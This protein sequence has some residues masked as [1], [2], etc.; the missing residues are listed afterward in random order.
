MADK[1]LYWE[2][3]KYFQKML[4]LNKTAFTEKIKHII[5]YSKSGLYSKFEREGIDLNRA[6]KFARTFNIK[7]EVFAGEDQKL[8]ESCAMES[9]IEYYQVKGQHSTFDLSSLKEHRNI[10]KSLDGYWLEVTAGSEHQNYNIGKFSSK[11]NNFKYNGISYDAKGVLHHSWDTVSM[12]F[13]H[14]LAGIYYIYKLIKIGSMH[15]VQYGFGFLKTEYNEQ[16]QAW[17]LLGGYYLNAEK[18]TSPINT[19]MFRLDQLARKL[20]KENK[21]KLGGNSPKSHRALVQYLIANKP[22]F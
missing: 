8:F 14:D 3:M 10:I 2:R 12:Y 4:K 21:Y 7:M 5:G 18:E 11:A 22:D 17:G 20:E 15:N 9:I 6:A 1:K 13:E 19:L 16:Q